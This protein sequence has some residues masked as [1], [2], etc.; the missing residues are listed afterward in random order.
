MIKRIAT[1]VIV[2]AALLVS[3]AGCSDSSND[4][5]AV[6][7]DQYTNQRVDDSRCGG[8]NG[9]VYPGYYPYYYPVYVVAPA[10]GY[11]M[12]PG[13]Y[14]TLPPK[15][16]MTKTRVPATGGA[17]KPKAAP[18]PAST[19]KPFF[20]GGS[21]KPS[22]PNSNKPKSTYNQPPKS[23]GGAYKPPASA[24]RSASPPKTR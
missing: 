22:Q 12:T 21:S 6:C 16:R 11:P 15:A 24:P 17:P 1:A 3:L 4:Y 7:V 13:G 10:I 5:D 14:R 18:K 2:P 20:G 23:N 8:F 9:G 19:K